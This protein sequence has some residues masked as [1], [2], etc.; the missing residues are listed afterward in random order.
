MASTQGTDGLDAELLGGM[1]SGGGDAQGSAGVLGAKLLSSGADVESGVGGG[2]MDGI[3][4][5]L[6]Q[7]EEL[8]AAD[9]AD[10][11]PEM[12]ALCAH[13]SPVT[14]TRMSQFGWCRPCGVC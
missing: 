6:Q 2:G 9:P 3:G 1:A 8:K 5:L 11:P 4:Q 10:L 14:P 12:A 13:V 7:F